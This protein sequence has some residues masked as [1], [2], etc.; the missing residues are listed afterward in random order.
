LERNIIRERVVAGLEHARK[1]GTKSGIAVGRPRVIFRRDHI[2]ELRAAGMSWRQ[3]AAKLG[4]RVT[5]VRRAVVMAG[6]EI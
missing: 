1:H 2:L 6:R 4:A 5:T 3:I